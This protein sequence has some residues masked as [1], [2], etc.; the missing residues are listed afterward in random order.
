M[1]CEPWDVVV[2]PFPFTERASAKRRPSLV[3]GK[4]LFN[5]SG[6]SVMAMITSA[7]HQH[8]PGDTPIRDHG[9]AGLRVPCTIRLKLFTLDNRLILRRVGRLSAADRNRTRRNMQASLG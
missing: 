6:H 9:S 3:L 5:R 7:K 8:W 1:I 2:V 4:K